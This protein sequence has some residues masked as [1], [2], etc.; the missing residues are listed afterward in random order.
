MRALFAVVPGTRPAAVD[1][2]INGVAVAAPLV[3]GLLVGEPGSGALA[4]LGAYVAAFTNKGGPRRTRTLGLCTA[5]AAN[6]AAFLL[7][8][9]TFHIVAAAVVLVS[10]LVFVAAMGSAVNATAARLGTMPA[11][12]FLASSIVAGKGS[13]EI[14]LGAGL[15]LGGGLFYALATW[16][17][18]PVRRV[19]EVLLAVAEPFTLLGRSLTA[20]A[21]DGVGD[22]DKSAD[23]GRLVAAVRSAEAAVEGVATPSGD[24]QLAGQLTRVVGTAAELV[25]LVAALDDLGPPDV[26]VAAACRRA[27]AEIGAEV[28]AVGALLSRRRN[29]RTGA[30][31]GLAEV[32][33]ACDTLRSAV[34]DGV[35][36]YSRL[37][38]AGRYRRLLESLA[39]TT[40]LATAAVE[41]IDTR[42]TLAPVDE[43][44]RPFV[45]IARL[46]AAMTLDSAEY[47]HA[48][49]ITAITA[50]FVTV[51]AVLE[52]PHGEW[53]ILAVLRVLRPQYG[54]TI[55]RA[56]QRVVGNVVGGSCAA[57]L[58]A[59]VSQ[60]AALAI[61][62]FVVIT[63]GFALR[64]VN[65]AFWVVFGTPLVLLIG[66]IADPGDWGAAIARIVMTLAGSAVALV[67]GYLLW[68]SW[69]RDRVADVV[70]A[71]DA[72][73]AEF[74]AVSL[75]RVL[76]PDQ[77][78][79]EQTRRTAEGMLAEARA[80]TKQARQEPGA[81]ASAATAGTRL[82]ALAR[83]QQHLAALDALPK[84]SATKIPALDD[85]IAITSTS[86]TD[87]GSAAAASAQARALET[88]FAYLDDAHRRRVDELPTSGTKDTPTRT[89]VR[90]N[91][92]LVALFAAIASE[93]ATVI[94]LDQN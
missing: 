71:A 89:E 44:R 14:L 2:L 84:S 22:G 48:L 58:I 27:V 11:T 59:T 38:A 50:G 68:P 36:P 54:A 76:D 40:A 87:R 42:G 79:F 3:V 94:E 75:R 92:P 61:I 45:D 7:G 81:A 1:G 28:A 86:L 24:E 26:A 90:E 39:R 19:D 60:P 55:E 83:L 88:M 5:A 15:V 32:T 57:V 78:R 4:C 16:V 10:A 8:A 66:D 72:A 34:V 35:E 65:Y 63:I 30:G 53:G 29:V 80:V 47:R 33:A 13:D 52:L 69:Q 74:L 21:G 64:P 73:T 91:E 25:D 12:A 31:A 20:R 51:V 46:R 77:D 49:R 23:H 82:D 41:T 70:R 56:G 37:V 85:Y 18:T 67:G 62:L 93:I 6:A 17:C 9:F 43:S